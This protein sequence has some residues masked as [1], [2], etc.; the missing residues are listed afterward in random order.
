MGVFVS[1]AK[2]TRIDDKNKLI[3]KNKNSSFLGEG[4]EGYIWGF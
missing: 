1:I 4:R 3:F 2:I